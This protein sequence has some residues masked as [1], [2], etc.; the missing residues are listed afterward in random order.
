MSD[1]IKVTFR[2][3]IVDNINQIGLLGYKPYY[4]IRY[5]EAGKENYNIGYSSYDLE[6]VK[7]WWDE[8]F[9]D[10]EEECLL[11]RILLMIKCRKMKI[12]DRRFEL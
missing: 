3:I 10:V 11:K 1:K 7:K 6:Y 12:K 9:E 5:R 2:E 8:Y 4:S